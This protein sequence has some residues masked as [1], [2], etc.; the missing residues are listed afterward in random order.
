VSGAYSQVLGAA[1]VVALSV[2]GCSSHPSQGVSTS[3]SSPESSV[4][5]AKNQS[6]ACAKSSAP[7][8]SLKP[9]AADEP[10][11]AIPQPQGWERSTDLDSALIRGV[12]ANVGLR[13][14]GFTP[15]AVATL[16]DTTGKVQ[17]AQQAVDAEAAGVEQGGV[18]VESQTPG[19]ICGQS[20]KT[21]NYTLQNRPVTAVIVA[22]EHEQ[23]IWAAVLTVQTS[24]PENPKYIADKQTILNGFQFSWPGKG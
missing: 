21:I 2:A 18:A 12:I 22:A 16:E 24:E 3:A 17:T 1:V 5:V 7:M 4:D 20:S 10:T 11:L 6:T 23:K 19:T 15:N 14:N 13:A 9:H 8:L